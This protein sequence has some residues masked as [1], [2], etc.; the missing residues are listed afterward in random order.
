MVRLSVIAAAALLLFG[1]GATARAAEPASTPVVI[2]QTWTLDSKVLGTPR[3]VSLY[4]PPSYADGKQRYPVLYLIDGGADQDFHHI[5]GLA[6]LATISGATQE[7]IV[8]GIETKDRTNELTYPTG[9]PRYTKQWP[10]QGGAPKF[11][12][13]IAEEVQP[14]VDARYRTSGETALMGESLAGLFV[15]DSFLRQPGLADR[16][17]AVSPSLWWDSG[18]LAKDAPALL[19]AQDGADRTLWLTIADEG[20]SMQTAMD[21]LV[22][23]LKANGPKSLKWSYAPRPTETHASIYHGAALDALR[24]L[25]G[26]DTHY[27]DGKTPWW[28]EDAPGLP[29]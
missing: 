19:K 11:R 26:L 20:G 22:A 2:G 28:L 7:F 4:L 5:T 18:S 14:F 10:T 9:D 3:K 15:V 23:A 12:R 17:V 6:Q 8:V 1:W 27:G 16:Y 24:S 13:F 29:K 25:W 21:G